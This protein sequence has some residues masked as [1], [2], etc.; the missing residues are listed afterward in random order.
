MRE[1]Y[2]R[3]LSDAAESHVMRYLLIARELHDV[4]IDVNCAPLLDVATPSLHPAIGERCL[5]SNPS[6]VAGLAHAVR[7]GLAAGGVLPVVKHLPGYGRSEVDPHEHLP[8]VRASREELEADF[9]PFKAHNDC[10]M[11]MTAHLT[12]EAVDSEYPVTF[13]GPCIDLIRDDIGFDGLLMTDDISMGAL[14]GTI[15]ERSRAS[16][17]AGCDI[18][19]HCNG[20][21]AEMEAVATGAELLSGKALGRAQAVDAAPRTPDDIDIEAVEARYKALKQE[22]CHA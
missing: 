4:G 16:I 22:A 21:R 3:S 17:D 12:I 6:A 11:G 2:Q 7:K 18:V 15:E 19:L 13:S 9:A 5:G 10:L 14:T 20:E 1:A 8:V